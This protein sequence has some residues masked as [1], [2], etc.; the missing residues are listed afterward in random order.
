MKS[1]ESKRLAKR[2]NIPRLRPIA[3]SS[4]GLY[5]AYGSVC[6]YYSCCVVE[7]YGVMNGSGE[8]MDL[9]CLVNLQ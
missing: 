9:L 6:L 3:I 8:W 5:V 2:M 7:S 1:A 4:G